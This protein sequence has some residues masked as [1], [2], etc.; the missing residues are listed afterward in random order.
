[1]THGEF[2]Q[3]SP[4]ESSEVIQFTMQLHRT[5]LH[6]GRPCL[7]SM[8]QSNVP[9]PSSGRRRD[10]KLETFPV[11]FLLSSNSAGYWA[12]RTPC[13]PLQI[14]CQLAMFARA[15]IRDFSSPS[16]YE[17]LSATPWMFRRLANVSLKDVRGLY[18][19]AKTQ[20][21]ADRTSA[22]M[23]ESEIPL[24]IPLRGESSF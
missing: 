11:S 19:T 23:R 22:G 16:S 17:A 8:H 6:S 21:K 7:I 9:T 12:Y 5:S 20:Y 3:P 4:S 24:S 13:L 10:Q 2:T 14:L 15:F 18:Q 1:M